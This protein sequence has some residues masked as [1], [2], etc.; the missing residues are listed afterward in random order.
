[1]ISCGNIRNKQF[2]VENTRTKHE[3]EIDMERLEKIYYKLKEA[4]EEIK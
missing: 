3:H 1:M 4:L 2:V